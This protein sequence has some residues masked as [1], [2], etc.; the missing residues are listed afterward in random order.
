MEAVSG[1]TQIDVANP[2]IDIHH[3]AGRAFGDDSNYNEFRDLIRNPWQPLNCARDFKQAMRFVK[4]QYPKSQIDHHFNYGE[5]KIADR[6]SY[7]FGWTMYNQ[8]YVM[9]NHLPKWREGSIST[10]SGERFFYG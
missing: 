5:F 8:I 10:P 4:V 9:D 7:T 2:Q 6:F 1:E 3:T